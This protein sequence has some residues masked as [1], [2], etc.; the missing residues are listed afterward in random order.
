[1]A[2]SGTS[3]TIPLRP[4]PVVTKD[5]SFFWDGARQHRLLIQRCAAC[6]R[7]R[8]PPTAACASCGA[9]TWDVIQSTG[10]GELYSYTV[11]HAPV[12]PPFEAPHIV[13]LVQ[14]SEGTRLISELVGVD[15]AQVHIGMTLKLDWL[16]A[17]A[18]LALPVFRPALDDLHD[19]SQPSR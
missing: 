19:V 3:T 10:A 7:L 8:H 4:R 5:T 1:M 6:H 13:G 2:D 14:L 11:I 18:D 15:P 17:D 9:L 16:D 12:V